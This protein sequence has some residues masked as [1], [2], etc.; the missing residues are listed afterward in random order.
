MIGKLYKIAHVIRRILQRCL[1][2]ST[3][4][5]KALIINTNMEILLVKHTYL[6]GW[7]LPGG[8]LNPGESPK[9]AIIREVKE[10]A[11]IL[12]TGVLELFHVY[13]HKILGASDYPIL[14]IVREFKLLDHKPCPREILTTQWFHY[15]ALPNDAS[16]STLERVREVFLQL[17][18]TDKW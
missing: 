3:V 12:V 11:A 5:V 7:H 18:P 8:G 17:P 13:S 16:A 1:N 2:M 14:Y 15:S 4:G 10:E 6:S 9:E